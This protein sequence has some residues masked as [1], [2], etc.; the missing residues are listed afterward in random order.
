MDTNNLSILQGDLANSSG[1][2]A[3][4]VEQ[5][6]LENVLRQNIGKLGTFY[7]TYTGSN[8]WRD[9]AYKGIIEAVGRD[10][11]IIRDPKNQKYYLFQFVYFD[12]AE[13]D[14]RI[15]QNTK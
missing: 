3:P 1:L 8:D 4:I 11:F 13:F 15:V 7:F 9:R 10:H 5:T 2:P 12:W 6:Y 14:E